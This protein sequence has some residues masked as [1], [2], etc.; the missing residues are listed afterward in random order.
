[1][2]MVKKNP[3]LFRIKKISVSSVFSVVNPETYI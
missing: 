1:M 3:A 2:I